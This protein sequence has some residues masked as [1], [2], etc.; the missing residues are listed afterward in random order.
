MQLL[1]YITIG[2]F[3]LGILI[4][5]LSFSKSGKNMKSFL[6]PADRFPGPLTDCRFSWVS[7]LRELLWCGARLLILTDGW[8]LPF[9]R[10][11]V[12][13]VLVSVSLLPPGGGRQG[14]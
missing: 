9:K 12:L 8:Q 10:P 14:S 7:F 1:D 2:L 3:T 5:G 13:P 6:R 11:C 4:A